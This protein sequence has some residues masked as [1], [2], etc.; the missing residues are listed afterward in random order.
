MMLIST[1]MYAFMKNQSALR[2]LELVAEAGFDCMDLTLFEMATGN[3]SVF[4][5]PEGVDYARMLRRKAEELSIS[6]NQAHAPFQMDMKPWL[7]GDR[8]DILWRLTQAI[9]VAAAAGAKYV[10]V[11]PVQCMNY[12]N[13]DPQ[14]IKQVN[15]EFYGLLA[16]VAKEAGILI[17]I[18][19]MWQFHRYNPKTIVS[20]VCADPYE[21]RDYVDAC[22]AIEPVFT[23]CLDVG[24]S[25]LTGYDPAR[26]IRILGDR[27]GC[28]HLHDVS[29]REDSHTC[30]LT[31]KVD[32]YDIMDALREIGYKGE[33]TLEALS[34]FYQFREEHRFNALLQLQ[35]V[36]SLLVGRA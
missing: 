18:E 3:E 2:C 21:H 34:F 32:F 7:E 17:A 13:S 28:L 4:L 10:V 22:N 30:P 20:S 8:E 26:S 14:W 15:L 6:I 19:N 36:S 5:G 23:A 24:H 1:E 11:H 35:R 12:L 9:R 25:V 33:F 16:P 29:G 27:L 31:M